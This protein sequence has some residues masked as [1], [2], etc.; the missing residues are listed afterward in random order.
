MDQPL[1]ADWAERELDFRVALEPWTA[2][3]HCPGSGAACL[4]SLNRIH[5]GWPWIHPGPASRLHWVFYTS[6]GDCM[7]GILKQ[8]WIDICVGHLSTPCGINEIF[9]KKIGKFCT[10]L[11]HF[12]NFPP[13]QGHFRALWPCMWAARLCLGSNPC[14]GALD[15]VSRALE[16]ALDPIL[17][18]GGILT[19]CEG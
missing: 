13:L 18:Q 6:M 16:L 2:M 4:G 14:Q 3:W 11:G 1:R 9:R 17:I 7:S 10:H 5:K 8:H 12:G 15:T 19:F